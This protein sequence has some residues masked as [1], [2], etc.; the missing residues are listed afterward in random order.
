MEHSEGLRRAINTART[1][2]TQGFQLWLGQ[3][4]KSLGWP[5]GVNSVAGAYVEPMDTY[6]DMSHLIGAEAWSSDQVKG[7]GYFCGVM[8]RVD[9][10]TEAQA[11]DRVKQAARDFAKQSIAP[12]WPQAVDPATG[13]LRN[14]VLVGSSPDRM[15]DQYYRA[16]I[17]GT[18]L[19]VLTP[20]GTVADRVPSDA[21]GFGNL[22]L[23]GDWTRNG[24]D[25]GCVEAAATSGRQAARALTGAQ[26]PIYGEDPTW[27]THSSEPPFI[28]YGTLET[29]PGPFKCS[30]GKFLML[31][32]PAN[33]ARVQALLARVLNAAS[34]DGT[35]Y[36]PL[37]S[38]VVLMLGYIDSISSLAPGFEDRGFASEWQAT[39]TIPAVAGV[40]IA[41]HF[42]PKRVVTFLPYLLVDN[43]I[44]LT[45]GREIYGLA[46]ALG[47]FPPS[48]PPSDWREHEQAVKGFGGDFGSTAQAGWQDLLRVTPLN[49]SAGGGAGADGGS[50]WSS[51]KAFVHHLVERAGHEIGAELKRLHFTLPWAAVAETFLD[52][53]PQVCLRQFRADDAPNLA[54]SRKVVE[55][56]LEAENLTARRS[57]HQWQVDLSVVD[58]HPVGLELGVI[59]G[60]ASFAFELEMDF[61]LR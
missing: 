6:C 52:A 25:G 40:E 56:R 46:K 2:A 50:E 61:V 27:L 26:A 48:P 44:S 33:Q 13:A 47:Q 54:S 43:T 34:T 10:E 24:I 4:T 31:G 3:D 18:E 16:N 17:S 53:V 55:V 60:L 57:A 37:G 49:S 22:V 23:A 32:L 12:L 30:G 35:R 59:S 41:G 8:P 1:T 39:L 29:S 5:H 21:S 20:A 28:E 14:D 19:Y 15:D 38:H 9:G 45:G 58:S 7:I 11:I 51:V 36:R 42:V